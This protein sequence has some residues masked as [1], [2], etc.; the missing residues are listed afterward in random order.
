M[1]VQVREPV[2]SPHLFRAYGTSLKAH[3][4]VDPAGPATITPQ[5]SLCVRVNLFCSKI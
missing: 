3:A 1:G 4:V 2:T 5:L